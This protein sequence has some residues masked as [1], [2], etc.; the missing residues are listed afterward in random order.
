MPLNTIAPCG[1]SP[2]IMKRRRSAAGSTRALSGRGGGTGAGSASSC[3]TLEPFSL[4][5]RDACRDAACD[6]WWCD[7]RTE[8]AVRGAAARAGTR[9][10]RAARAGSAAA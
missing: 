6:K 1:R 4:C 9:R 10:A 8:L 3:E 5:G 2:D 7:G